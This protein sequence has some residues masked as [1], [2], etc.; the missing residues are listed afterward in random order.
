[1]DCHGLNFEMM[2]AAGKEKATAWCSIGRQGST[3]SRKKIYK[4]QANKRHKTK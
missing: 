3:K 4:S 2:K 1:M